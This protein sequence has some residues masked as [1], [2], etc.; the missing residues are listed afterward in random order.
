MQMLASGK[1]QEAVSPRRERGAG[2]RLRPSAPSSLAAGESR[3]HA[4]TGM[5][6]EG[7]KTGAGGAAQLW[8]SLFPDMPGRPQHRAGK[9]ALAKEPETPQAL[10]LWAATYTPRGRSSDDGCGKDRRPE[11]QVALGGARGY[12]GGSAF[13]PLSRCGCCGFTCGCHTMPKAQL[14]L[15]GCGGRDV[16]GYSLGA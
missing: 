15:R 11:H 8:Q 12:P 7:G 5:A 14:S 2:R 4:G 3:D 10:V 16:S 6:G 1:Q 9:P 13:C